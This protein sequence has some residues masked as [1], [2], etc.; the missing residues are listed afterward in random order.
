MEEM[1]PAEFDAQIAAK[2]IVLVPFGTLEWHSYHLPIGLDALKAQAICERVAERTGAILAPTAYWAVGGVPFPYTLRFDL[3]LIESLAQHLFQQMGMLGFRA[4]AAITGHYGLEQLLAIK[5]A[6]VTTMRSSGLTIFAG[7][8]YEVVTDLG[9][10][11]DHAAKWETS[12]LAATRPDLVRMQQVEPGRPLD[13][14]LGED[15]RQSASAKL[16]DET[17][18]EIVLR[19]SKLA[20][21]I[22]I[23]RTSR[24][25]D[26]LKRPQQRSECS[27]VSKRSASPS[28][29]LSS[30]PW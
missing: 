22:L 5:R 10:H 25:H 11:G 2:P 16:G 7:G 26:M 30:R 24:A 4:I 23:C 21:R 3:N 27:S 20:E 6:A 18:A 28:R 13:G 1:L 12:L 14:I 17:A 9:Y 19:L 8:E 15:P 29:G